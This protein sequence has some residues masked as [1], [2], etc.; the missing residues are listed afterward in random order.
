MD[1][2]RDLETQ[3]MTLLRLLARWAFMLGILSG[4]PLALPVPRWAR[5]FADTLL[6]RAEYAAQIMVLVSSRLQT[7]SG[8][9]DPIGAP[10]SQRPRTHDAPSVQALIRRIAA[11]RDTL[12]NLHRHTRRLL[13]VQIIAGEAFDWLKRPV[14][15]PARDRVRPSHAD[16]VAPKETRPPDKPGLL[17][18]VG[19]W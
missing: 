2:N 9:A 5:T 18:F 16:W 11:L 19:S 10:C 6:T 14:S 12:E 4:G 17:S 13:R 7:T 3:R 8:L 15:I 1:L